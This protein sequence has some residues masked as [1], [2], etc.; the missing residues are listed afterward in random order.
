L[1]VDAEGNDWR[2]DPDNGGIWCW[3]A[4][5]SEGGA[6]EPAFQPSK[7]NPRD[8]TANW[9][10]RPDNPFGKLGIDV[11]SS[12]FRDFFSHKYSSQSLVN[13]IAAFPDLIGDPQTQ[14]GGW[15]AYL[16][17]NSSENVDQLINYL[18]SVK[19]KVMLKPVPCQKPD[20]G[21][22][23][24][25]GVSSAAGTGMMAAMMPFPANAIG[26]AVAIGVG[27]AQGVTSAGGTC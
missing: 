6:E 2:N 21:G 7:N 26:A 11:G 14:I 13:N 8:S 5:T 12:L 16:R 18:Y 20:I 27:I 19:N 10:S 24:L 17:G 25:T 22:A 1:N 15:S 23:V 3:W 9:Y 4:A